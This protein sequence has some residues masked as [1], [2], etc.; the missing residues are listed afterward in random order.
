MAPSPEQVV[1]WYTRRKVDRGPLLSRWQE[2][3]QQY[4]GDV[5]V[6]LP[7]LDE[8]EKAS[9][10]NLMGQGLDQMAMRV[11]SIVPDIYYPSIRPG[12]KAS[13]NKANDRQKANKGWWEANKMQL[14]LRKRAR[15]LLG[16][17]CSPVVL[18]PVAQNPL[19]KREIP[20]WRVINPMCAFPAVMDDEDLEPPNCIFAYRQS[21]RWLDEKFPGVSRQLRLQ[22]NASPDTQ[23]EI[24]EYNDDEVTMLVAVGAP[25]ENEPRLGGYDPR[26]PMTEG[27]GAA[28]VQLGEAL[29]NKAGIPLTVYPGRITLGRMQG[30]YD[31]IMPMYQRSAKLDALELWAIENAIFPKEW[32]VSHPN[33]PGRPQVITYADGRLGIVGEIS[34]G[35]VMT[36]SGNA[37]SAQMTY[38]AQDRLERA[39]RFASG[40]SPELGGESPSNVRTATRGVNVLGSVIDMPIQEHQDI[41]AASLEAE[42]RRAV[43][44]MKA[45]YGSKPTSFHI[46]MNG[47]IVREDYT[48]KDT[49]ETDTNIVKYGMSGTDINGWV[50]GAGQRLQME[51]LSPESFMEM[52]PYVKDVPQEMARI[53]L[54]G[55]RKALQ[56]SIEQEAQQGAFSSANIARLAQALRDGETAFE[57]AVTSV[58]EEM[59]QEQAAQA[60]QQQQ[61]TPGTP[62]Q[63][64]QMPGLA[65]TPPQPGVP[66]QAPSAGNLSQILGN[67]HPPGS[68]AA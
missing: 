68:N 4:N 20:H 2:V 8:N 29:P 45:Y 18:N 43:A 13:E 5:V 59:Q 35:T 9:V 16:Y 52:D 19:D 44:I 10:V 30:M 53:Y 67:L 49:F 48:P 26:A 21:V 55:V 58:H 46:P 40:S 34:N 42:N 50:V 66:N 51:T 14:L 31:Q 33:S 37:G 32:I 38:M 65:G 15:F 64:G 25:K 60:A 54:S 63:P 62:P 17:G 6:P 39:Q 12:I 27:G 23:I 57:D 28:A 3:T 61:Q 36:G 1:E 41:F 56:A 7:E 24:L 47:K 11:A 22:K